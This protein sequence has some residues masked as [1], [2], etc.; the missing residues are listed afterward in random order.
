MR[1]K[2]SKSLKEYFEVVENHV[3]TLHLHWKMYREVFAHSDR[4]IKILNDVAPALWSTIQSI[5]QDTVYLGIARLLDSEHTCGNKNINMRFIL[6]MYQHDKH[7]T[8]AT[9]LQKQFD[10]VIKHFDPFQWHRHKRL[11]HSDEIASM[12]AEF[13]RPSRAQIEL[14]LEEIRCFMNMVREHE[15]NCPMAYEHIQY[16]GG[17]DS[18]AYWLSQGL[19]LDQLRMQLWKGD[20]SPVQVAEL[21]KNEH[22]NVE[23]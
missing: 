6:R 15:G 3:S 8:F 22:R 1:Q 21:I 14:I 16:H 12:Q 23:Y 11:A 13:T 2:P 17:G 10:I 20:I 18:L 19:W 7:H 5:M 9:L 4:R